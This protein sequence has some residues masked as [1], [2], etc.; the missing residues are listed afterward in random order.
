MNTNE[1]STNESSTNES[2]T[3]KQKG[4]IMSLF[5]TPV[6]VVNIDRSFTKDEVDCITDIPM[7]KDEKG[8]SNH[9]SE[10]FYLFDNFVEELKDI[11]ILCEHHLKQY[12][13]YIKGVD[14]N[15]VTLR[16]T[17]SW[18]NK[19]KPGEYH[20]MHSHANS[21]LSGILY[22]TCLPNDHIN[23][24]NRMYGMYNNMELSTKKETVWNSMG[25]VVDVKKGDL[26]IFPSWIP[27]HVDV[28]ETKDNERISLSFNTFPIGEMGD[29][30]GSHLK[31]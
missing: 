3:N 24:T 28:N 2:S 18:L 25:V 23:L 7:Y 22:I 11:K 6:V 10:D 20:H 8:M 9:Q 16:I 26:I 13:E 27:H 30:Y 17:Q 1:S 19:T 31:L 29:Y 15:K 12:L 4:K 5:P 21:Y 14:T